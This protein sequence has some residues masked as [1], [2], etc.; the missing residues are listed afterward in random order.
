MKL[1]GTPEEIRN[2]VKSEGT[3]L[4][5]YL[6]RPRIRAQSLTEWAERNPYKIIIASFCLGLAAAT[7]VLSYTYVP[8]QLYDLKQQLTACEQRFARQPT[9]QQLFGPVS[10]KPSNPTPSATQ[11]ASKAGVAVDTVPQDLGM[12]LEDLHGRYE[13]LKDRFA[14]QEALVARCDQKHV[15]WQVKVDHVEICGKAVC[16]TFS[17]KVG[18]KLPTWSAHFPGELKQRI[19]ALH[20]G[21]MIEIEGVL[22]ASGASNYLEVE[23]GTFDVVIVSNQPNQ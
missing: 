10:E 9:N 6:K 12:S 21:D 14:E 3:V 23:A 13:A 19:Y 16:I 15:R 5:K 2:L 11:P 20:P 22:K 17:S 4:S 7:A 18:Q 1:E 8:Y